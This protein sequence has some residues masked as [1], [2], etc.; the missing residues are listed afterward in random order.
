MAS[1]SSIKNNSSIQRTIFVVVPL[2]HLAGI[3]GLQLS[4]SES[5]FKALVPFHLLCSLI[6]LL[7]FHENWNRSAVIFCVF[8]YLVGFSVEALG[9]HTGVIFGHYHYGETLGTKLIDIPL[10]IGINWL[11]LIY[12]TGIVMEKIKGNSFFKLIIAAAAIVGIDVLIEPVAI[13]LDFW[14][15]ENGWIPLQN[16]LAWYIVAFGLLAFFHFS[17]FIK[18]NRL[19]PL[20]LL[21]QVAFFLAHNLLFLLK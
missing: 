6:L 1:L 13:R 12:S 11:A 14:S 9:V 15:W 20:F 8:T 5:L 4:L 7:I 18:Q 10:T 21:C 2:M 17:N 16:Y 19:A 3:V